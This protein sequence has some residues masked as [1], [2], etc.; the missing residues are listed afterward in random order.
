MGNLIVTN[1][2]FRCTIQ[3]WVDMQRGSGRFAR[4]D[5]E[6]LD[7]LFLQLVGEVILSAE[8]NYTPLGDCD[9]QLVTFVITVGGPRGQIQRLNNEE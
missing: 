8:N 5:P 1:A 6:R 4:E 3:H 7:E 2:E 9:D